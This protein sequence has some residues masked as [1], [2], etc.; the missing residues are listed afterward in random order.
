VGVVDH[1]DGTVLFAEVGELID[2]ADVAVHG[3]D[4]VGDEELAA[5]LVLNFLE[6]LLGVGDVF[7]AEDLDLGL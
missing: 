6:E 2:G 3:E 5:G 1:H 7:V 4:T